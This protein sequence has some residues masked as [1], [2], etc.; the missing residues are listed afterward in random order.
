MLARRMLV[1][2][3]WQYAREPRIG[4]TLANRQDGQPDHVLQISNRAQQRLHHLY[5]SDARPRQAAQRDRRRG[6]PRAG[7]LP[8][9]RRHRTLIPATLA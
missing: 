5:T 9:G 1:E 4:V 2:S 8:L 6:R 3:A 7:L